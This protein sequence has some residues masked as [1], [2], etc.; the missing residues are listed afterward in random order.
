MNIH[1]TLN[2]RQSTH[3]E[4]LDRAKMT[5][6]LKQIMRTGMRWDDLVD[7]ERE[8]LDMLANKIGRILSG[9]PHH[10]D[11]WHDIAGYATLS[12]DRNTPEWWDESED[13]VDFERPEWT[14]Q[15]TADELITKHSELMKDIETRY[16]AMADKPNAFIDG[17]PDA[18]VGTPLKVD[19]GK[20]AEPLIPKPVQA[21][22][23]APDVHSVE[24]DKKFWD[25][26]A[27]FTPWLPAGTRFKEPT[28]AVL[29]KANAMSKAAT[30]A[31][32]TETGLNVAALLHPFTTTDL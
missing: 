8:T 22:Y 23:M 18:A 3:G 30:E 19:L 14:E 20:A 12:A 2:D 5:Q 29:E 31:N 16:L 7:H 9:N 15:T 17:Q 4:Y 24:E 11:H 26:R 6:T 27:K 32:A 28:L 1:D 10:H 21:R 25:L 13:H